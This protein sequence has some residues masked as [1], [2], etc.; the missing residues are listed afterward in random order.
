MAD[1]SLFRRLKRLFSTN[2][3]VRNIG[4]RKLK[5][6]DVDQRQAFKKVET[7]FIDRYTRIRNGL[8]GQY[9]YSPGLQQTYQRM[10]NP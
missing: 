1:T 3:I 9:G 6:S 7:N 5:V 8:G 2:V 10:D 4:G